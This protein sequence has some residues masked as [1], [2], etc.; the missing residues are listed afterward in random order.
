MCLHYVIVISRYY[1]CSKKSWYNNFWLTDKR[2]KN[3]NL[4]PFGYPSFPCLSALELR[5]LLQN[6]LLTPLTYECLGDRTFLVSVLLLQLYILCYFIS[7]FLFGF[8]FLEKVIC[9][10]IKSI[11]FIF[12][13]HGFKANTS[14]WKFLSWT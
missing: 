3:I 14:H 11:G 13:L 5:N 8:I 1:K 6:H 4:L 10:F 7:V 2:N 9:S 12:G